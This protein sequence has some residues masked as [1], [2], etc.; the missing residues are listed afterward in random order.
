MRALTADEKNRSEVARKR[1]NE[2][3]PRGRGVKGVPV[4]IDSQSME[5]IMNYDF[6]RKMLRNLK[7][8][9]WKVDMRIWPHYDVMVISYT[10]YLTVQGTTRPKGSGSMELKSLPHYQCELLT[11]LPIIQIES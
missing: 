4:V 2:W 10:T 1:A 11:D 7:P 6:I 3:L 8:F 9:D 5:L